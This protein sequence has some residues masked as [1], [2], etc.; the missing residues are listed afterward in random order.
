MTNVTLFDGR[1]HVLSSGHHCKFALD[2][3]TFN[4]VTQYV[5]YKRAISFGDFNVAQRILGA[6]LPRTQTFLGRIAEGN[7]IDKCRNRDQDIGNTG[8]AD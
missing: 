6:Q 5:Q 4:C 3:L 2:G 7:N 1:K 8:T